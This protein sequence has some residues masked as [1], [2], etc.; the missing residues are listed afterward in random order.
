VIVG[1]VTDDHRLYEVPK[2]TVAALRFT[3][4]ARARITKSGGKC[5]TIDELI[6]KAPTG[7]YRIEVFFSINVY[8][9]IYKRVSINLLYCTIGTNTLL[10][11]GSQDREAKKHF[12]PAPGVKGSHTK[13]WVR[14]KGRKFERCKAL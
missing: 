11:R 3:E 8:L 4:T 7:R 1:S 14:H 2:M 10:L 13:P 12:G 6:M 5:M 9:I